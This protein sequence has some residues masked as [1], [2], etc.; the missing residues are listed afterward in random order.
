MSTSA[1]RSEAVYVFILLSKNWNSYT[2]N[3]YFIA[4][5]CAITLRIPNFLG[6]MSCAMSPPILAALLNACHNKCQKSVVSSPNYVW[7]DQK[8]NNISYLANAAIMT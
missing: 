7:I 2:E 6:F 1:H 5:I 3:N 8:V 4:L